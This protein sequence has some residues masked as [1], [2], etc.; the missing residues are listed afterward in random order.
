MTAHDPTRRRFLELGG[1]GVATAAVVAACGGGSKGATLTGNPTS[2]T[3]PT[4]ATD[5]AT[6]NT[7]AALERV[8]FTFYQSALAT[9]GV[10]A[11]P[12]AVEAANLAQS[13]HATNILLFE[14]E[15]KKAGGTPSQ[16]AVA[17]VQQK[18]QPLLAAP[19]DETSALTSALAIERVATATYYAVVGSFH[20]ATLDQIAMSVGG[21]SARRA[22]VLA[23]IVKQPQV[24]RA[25]QTRDGAIAP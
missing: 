18:L 3:A 15:V 19:K 1:L 22:A 23:G 4:G 20:G 16:Q 8:A 6:L 25:F 13:Q 21:V 11:A 7:A 12:A 5:V 24:P 14:A 2:T 9:P 17:V 10:I